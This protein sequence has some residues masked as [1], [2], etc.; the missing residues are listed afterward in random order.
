VFIELGA[1]LLQ[2][3]V[4]LSTS[5]IFKDAGNTEG[6]GFCTVKTRVS[7]TCGHPPFNPTGSNLYLY[8]SCKVYRDEMK[9]KLKIINKEYTSFIDTSNQNSNIGNDHLNAKLVCKRTLNFLLKDFQKQK[10]SPY[11]HTQPSRVYGIPLEE[12][13]PCTELNPSNQFCIL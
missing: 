6:G 5:A 13:I 12:I 9:Y 11:T 10:I 7:R 1:L 8:S 2:N 3:V 4:T